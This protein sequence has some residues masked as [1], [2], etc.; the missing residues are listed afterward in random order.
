MSNKSSV[1]EG[2][3]SSTSAAE[4][5]AAAFD[6]EGGGLDD[7]DRLLA[8]LG[9]SEEHDQRVAFHEAD[10]LVSARLFGHPLGG[11][12]VDPGPGYEG[13]V[14]GATHMEAFAEGRGDASDVREALASAMPQAGDDVSSVSD[15]FAN[16]YGHCIELMAGRAAERM[17]LN[18][19]AP[20]PTDDLRQAR[21]LATLICKSEEATTAF[22]A[23]C[24]FAARDLLMPFGDVVIVVGAADVPAP[25]VLSCPAIFNAGPFTLHCVR[26]A[27]ARSC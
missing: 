11:A 10:H 14:W 19:E 3:G 16:V 4:V 20:I 17:L 26:Q 25:M 27:M 13:R 2:K 1:D 9:R 21:E 22:L 8:R 7:H 15:V 12:T 18:G 5:E 6:H 24:D 23:H